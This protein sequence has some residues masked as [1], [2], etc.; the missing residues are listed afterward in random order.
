MLLSSVPVFWWDANT[1]CDLPKDKPLL[2][3][4]SLRDD[5]DWDASVF[6]TGHDPLDARAKPFCYNGE[7]HVLLLKILNVSGKQQF[8]RAASVPGVGREE[9]TPYKTT[10]DALLD[11]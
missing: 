6:Q 10:N 8:G 5:K 2:C 1:S 3:I 4:S 11:P 9:A 7:V